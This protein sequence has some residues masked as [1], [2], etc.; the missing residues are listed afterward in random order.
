MVRQIIAPDHPTEREAE[1][2]SQ[3][4]ISGP[5]MGSVPA[6]DRTHPGYLQRQ[7]SWDDRNAL[8]WAD[9][10]GPV[11]KDSPFD[12]STSSKMNLPDLKPKR[13]AQPDPQK[14]CKLGKKDD[15][16]F[17]ATVKIDPAN[18]SVR[19]LMYPS[20]SWVKAGKQSA[21]LLVHEQGHFDITHVI[22][23]KAKAAIV[24]WLIAHV[25]QA[26]KC[27]KTP[28]LNAATKAWNAMNANAAIQDIWKRAGALLEKA[29]HDYDTDTN[30]GRN[31]AQQQSWLGDIASGLKKYNL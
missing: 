13:E 2:V 11:P 10:K 17:T 4:V 7:F 15:A 14:P 6:I 18:I 16:Q 8:N 30:H 24:N 31:A 29:Q 1:A 19:A 9:F 22:A 26:T 27:G 25:A 20:E 21:G 3:V 28:A 12:A 5:A 23:G